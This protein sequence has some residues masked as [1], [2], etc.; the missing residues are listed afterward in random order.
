MVRK[1]RL[2]DMES[3][4]N[5]AGTLFTFGKELEYLESGRIAQAFANKRNIYRIDGAPPNY[6]EDYLCVIIKLHIDVCQSMRK[7]FCKAF[8]K[9]YSSGSGFSEDLPHFSRR[10]AMLVSSPWSEGW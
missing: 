7:V 3:L 2:G 5:V 6:I 4:Q 10:L 9:D 8:I 1:G